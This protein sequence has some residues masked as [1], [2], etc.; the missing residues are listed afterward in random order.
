MKTQAPQTIIG[1]LKSGHS[2]N[3]MVLLPTSE[4]QIR[5]LSQAPQSPPTTEREAA[6]RARIESI[7]FGARVRDRLGQGAHHEIVDGEHVVTWRGRRFHGATVDEAIKAAQ[8]AH[9]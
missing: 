8:E 9:Q 1:C 3:T 5:P 7:R 2:N 6:R 4:R